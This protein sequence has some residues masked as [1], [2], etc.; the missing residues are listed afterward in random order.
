[1]QLLLIFL[2][3]NILWNVKWKYAMVVKLYSL[4]IGNFYQELSVSQSLK[5][6]LMSLGPVTITLIPQAA[7]VPSTFSLRTAIW[8]QAVQATVQ[9]FA[10]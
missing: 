7:D 5:P 10:S 1:M 8:K 3:N 2:C 6:Q 4:M 9:D